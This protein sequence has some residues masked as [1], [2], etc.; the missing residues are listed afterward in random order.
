MGEGSITV[1][2]RHQLDLCTG[3]PLAAPFSS[4]LKKGYS[5]F[6]SCEHLQKERNLWSGFKAVLPNTPR[7][8][9]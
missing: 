1:K 5:L 2:H 8:A 6:V 9:A 7:L 4:I 3:D